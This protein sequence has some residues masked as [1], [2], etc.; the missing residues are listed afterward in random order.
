MQVTLDENPYKDLEVHQFVQYGSVITLKAAGNFPCAYL[1]SHHQR[2]PEGLS[3]G[4]AQQMVSNYMHRDDNN[5]F[6]VKRWTRDSRESRFDDDIVRHGDRVI[7]EHVNTQR[8][9]HS[10]N[11]KALV[12]TDHYQVTGKVSDGIFAI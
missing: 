7:L 1:H 5:H 4:A 9:L 2:F 8:N 12:A 11:I 10:H 3:N 6:L